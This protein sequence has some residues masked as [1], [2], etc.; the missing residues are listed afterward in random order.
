MG[1]KWHIYTHGLLWPTHKYHNQNNIIFRCI[2]TN[3][4]STTLQVTLQVALQVA[5]QAKSLS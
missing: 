1:V 2:I 3:I 5:L 4:H